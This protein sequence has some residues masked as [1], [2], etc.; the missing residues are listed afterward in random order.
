MTVFD[1]AVQALFR[2]P[3]MT[4]GALWRPSGVGAGITIRIIRIQQ[5]AQFDIGGV[6]LV[7]DNVLFDVP[8]GMAPTI[9]E[10]D[11]IEAG[12][13][14]FK[15]QSPPVRSMDGRIGRVDLRRL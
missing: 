15:I 5:Q 3:N 12:G 11:T 9:D 4:E 14:V 1:T 7:Q 13:E 10:K 2:D 6:K 8:A